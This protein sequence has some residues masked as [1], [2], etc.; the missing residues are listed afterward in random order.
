MDLQTEQLIT[1]G[2][3]AFQRRDYAA[4]LADFRDVLAAHPDFPDVWHLSAVCLS[5]LGQPEAALEGL[6]R[7]LKLNDGYVEAHLNRALTLNE[8]GRYDEARDA[9]ERAWQ[10]ERKDAG[11]FSA[12]LSALLANAHAA[13]G[14]LYL[15]GGAVREAVEQYRLALG[16]RPRFVDI[17]NKLGRALFQLGDLAEAEIELKTTLQ[18]NPRFVAARVSLG[19][20]YYRRGA[21]EAAVREWEESLASAP[22]NPQARAFLAMLGRPVPPAAPPRP[23]DG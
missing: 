12:P 19:L 22:D 3:Q 15:Q 6:D 8:L 20:V 16:M 1:R 4:A 17:R 13:V 18:D 21:T 2:R 7:A 9:F 14:D 11:A 10:A 23:L 5:F